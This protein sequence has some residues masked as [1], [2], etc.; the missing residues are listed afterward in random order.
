MEY[1]VFGSAHVGLRECGG[2]IGKVG[3]TLWDDSYPEG[4]KL[5][6]I[7]PE[8]IWEGTIATLKL[9]EGDNDT[10]CILSL[11]I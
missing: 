2:L 7:L 5:E 1:S 8:L 9:K 3:L 6:Q 10:A 11:A 4:V